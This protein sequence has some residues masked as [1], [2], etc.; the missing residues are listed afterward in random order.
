MTLTGRKLF[1]L[2]VVGFFLVFSALV[3]FFGEKN[4]W[5]TLDIP[6]YHPSFIDVRGVLTG[7]D[8]A[9]LGFDPLYNN[10]LDPYKRRMAY[11]RLWLMAGW[12]GLSEKHTEIVAFLLLACYGVSLLACIAGY[13]RKT[14][15]WM[16]LVVCSPAALMCYRFANVDL[17]ICTLVL[18]ALTFER[19]S[20]FLS[21]SLFE[22][23][24][25]LKLFPIV[26]L[27]YLIK[28]EQKEFLRL[29]IL[30]VG[31]FVAYLVFTWGDVSWILGHAPKGALENYGVSVIAFRV[32]EILD[33]RAFDSLIIGSCYILLYVLC[34]IALYLSNRYK[35]SLSSENQRFMDAFRVGALIYLATFIQGNSFNYRFIFIILTIPQLVLWLRSQAELRRAVL[36]TLILIIFSCWGMVLTQILPV[37]LGF[38]LDEL[39][40]WGLFFCLF[41]MFFVSSPQWMRREI[42][43][44]FLRHQWRS[45]AL[46]TEP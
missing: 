26:G 17:I 30:S 28:E 27:V 42:R 15:V 16:T 4:V 36:S 41:Y 46:K 19:F 29:F 6:T 9:R 21:I 39:A 33:S 18:W 45:K 14:A 43:A 1:F 35:G 25:F 2:L 34:F 23:A 10:P 5:E 37:N 44:F 3:Y 38:A 8:A 13:D 22:L 11:P 24:A 20:T 31:I 12:L 7:L 40:N 32:Y